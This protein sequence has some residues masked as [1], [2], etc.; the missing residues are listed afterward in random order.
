MNRHFVGG[1]DAGI[2]W[3]LEVDGFCGT[4]EAK[5]QVKDCSNSPGKIFVGRFSHRS[6]LEL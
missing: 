3:Q 2:S 4:L 6:N 5:S 1:R